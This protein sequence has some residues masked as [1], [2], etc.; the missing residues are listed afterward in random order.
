MVVTAPFGH[1]EAPVTQPHPVAIPVASPRLAAAVDTQDLLAKAKAGDEAAF[2]TLIRRHQNMVFSVALH[3]LRSRPAA[4]DLAQEVFLELY[5]SL[6]RLESDAH[7]ISWLR[8]VAGHRCIDEI[9]RRNHRQE[10]ATDALPEPGHAPETRDVLGAE[11]LQELVAELP[12]RARM[13]VVLRY[14]EEMEPTE[15]AETL[16]MPVNTVKSH[17]R[18]S[19]IA[20]RERLIGRGE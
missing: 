9:R 17:L 3:M 4:E 6:D 15:I 10:Y 16:D 20:L 18:R 1:V 7:V 5:R 11:R 14:Q 2:A 12:P 8:R 13:V 19:I